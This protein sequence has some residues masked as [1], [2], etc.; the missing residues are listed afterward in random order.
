MEPTSQPID[1][2]LIFQDI[3]RRC[4]GVEYVG[5]FADFRTDCKE[6]TAILFT[7]CMQQASKFK[8]EKDTQDL[9]YAWMKEILIDVDN[10]KQSMECLNFL[11]DIP[12]YS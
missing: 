8:H 3:T 11:A 9:L 10:I 5:Y 2:E 7:I 4:F 1:F 6:R 12:I